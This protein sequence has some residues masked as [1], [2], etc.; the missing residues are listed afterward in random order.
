M[1]CIF[2]MDMEEECPQPTKPLYFIEKQKN[3]SKIY[4]QPLSR[5]NIRARMSLCYIYFKDRRYSKVYRTLNIT[6]CNMKESELIGFKSEEEIE[7]ITIMLN[8]AMIMM[9]YG[10]HKKVS[11]IVSNIKSIMD[12]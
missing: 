9:F 11:Q 5:N 2:T 1:E 4:V 12:K 6:L 7:Y 8:H 3:I 10:D